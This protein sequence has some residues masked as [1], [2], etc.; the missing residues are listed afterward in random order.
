[1]SSNVKST[2]ETNLN[3]FV[4]YCGLQ[5]EKF[6]IL[7]LIS[8]IKYNE[9]HPDICIKIVTDINK[10][11]KDE[12]LMFNIEIILVNQLNEGLG[13]EEKFLNRIYKFTNYQF[14]K[15]ADKVLYLDSDILPIVQNYEIWNALD[16]ESNDIGFCLETGKTVGNWEYFNTNE[17]GI[18]SQKY[19]QNDDLLYNGGLFLFKINEKSKYF[20]D[21]WRKEWEIFK[22]KDQLALVRA[23]KKTN[24]KIF[25]I[26]I[27]YNLCPSQIKHYNYKG[28]IVNVHLRSWVFNHSELLNFYKKHASKSLEVLLKFYQE[29]EII[30]FIS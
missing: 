13:D 25:P 22:T 10:F 26:D 23:V 21:Q 1:M 20:F 9:L 7:S 19:L 28:D 15:E 24:Q 8:A 2:Q 30:N 12:F 18:Y 5:K 11:S 6:L 16:D 27:K 3:R 29:S 17:Q 4:V 14:F